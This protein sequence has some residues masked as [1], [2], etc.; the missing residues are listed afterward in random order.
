MLASIS[1]LKS[2]SNDRKKIY[3]S[4]AWTSPGCQKMPGRCS[5]LPPAEPHE[6]GACCG[7][8]KPADRQVYPEHPK[9]DMSGEHCSQLRTGRPSC[10]RRALHILTMC[11]Q[12]LSGWKVTRWS[13]TK[14]T[15]ITV[16][17]SSSPIQVAIYEMQMCLLSTPPSHH[18]PTSVAHWNV[19]KSFWL[20]YFTDQAI[21]SFCVMVKLLD[22]HSAVRHHSH[23]LKYLVF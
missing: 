19:T 12:E 1:K 18:T 15:T 6:V 7:E 4:P 3:T 20:C 11:R 16:R 14:G 5:L 22:H 8:P 23:G 10:L 2:W 17:L 21:R 13:L 9:G